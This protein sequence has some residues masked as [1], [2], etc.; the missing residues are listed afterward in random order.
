MK[1]IKNSQV[2]LALGFVLMVLLNSC[3][4]TELPP[5]NVGEPRLFVRG[6]FNNQDLDYTIGNT[7]IQGTPVVLN[8]TNAARTFNFSFSDFANPNG[9]KINLSFVNHSPQFGDLNTDLDN[10]FVPGNKVIA[11]IFPSPANPLQLST[12]T[13]SL[14]DS[15]VV[16]SSRKYFSLPDSSF[17]K[18]DSVSD[19]TW[20][21]NITYKMVYLSFNCSMIKQSTPDSTFYQFKNAK[22]VIAFPK[23]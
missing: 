17:C 16:Y 14:T 3:Q 6:N 10:T 12:F 7:T 8:D 22:A 19:L 4:K 9:I 13:I 23:Q 5:S 11:D 1:T 20:L 15:S 21:D 2:L 18:I